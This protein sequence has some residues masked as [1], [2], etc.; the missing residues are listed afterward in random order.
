MKSLKKYLKKRKDKLI[1]LLEKPKQAYRFNTFHDLRVEIKKIN[2]LCNLIN[3]SMKG[4]RRKKIFEPFEIIFDQAGKVRELQIETRLLKKYLLSE[5]L[6]TYRKHLTR[7]RL[8]ERTLYFSLLDRKLIDS[9]K[10][11]FLEIDSGLDK[12]SEKDAKKFMDRME[13]KIENITQQNYMPIPQ[14]HELRKHLK[15][16]EY[17]RNSVDMDL[18]FKPVPNF[19]K[20]TDLLGEWHDGQVIIK[21]I[22]NATQS[23]VS[24]PKEKRHLQKIKAKIIA[25]N[26]TLLK[27]INQLRPAAK[28]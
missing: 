23:V 18:D 1:L 10:K 19:E 25:V 11:K 14:A 24:E 21:H 15:E 16:Y 13:N 9:M 3:E 6:N 12:V 20:M 28:I 26:K 8:K 4:F 7:G 5:M 17:T 2:A 22:A 27:K